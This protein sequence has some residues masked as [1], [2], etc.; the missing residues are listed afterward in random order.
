MKLWL[1]N[2]IFNFIAILFIGFIALSEFISDKLE[3]RYQSR[4]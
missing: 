3:E 1:E 4:I 2:T